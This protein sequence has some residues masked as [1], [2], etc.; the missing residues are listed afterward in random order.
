MNSRTRL[1]AA[2][3]PAA[4]SNAPAPYL[5]LLYRVTAAAAQGMSTTIM[6]TPRLT[7]GVIL[8]RLG[9]NELA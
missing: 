5:S 4:V 6:S 1:G 9:R 8:L 3:L 7:T 2:I